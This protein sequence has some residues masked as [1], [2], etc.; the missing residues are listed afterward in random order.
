MRLL[1]II[2]M[3]LFIIGG[4]LGE[5]KYKCYKTDSTHTWA[6]ITVWHKTDGVTPLSVIAEACEVIRK[7][8]E[9]NP[10]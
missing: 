9:N 5:K 4:C 8:R 10:K 1:I 3:I 7:A 2:T 6:I